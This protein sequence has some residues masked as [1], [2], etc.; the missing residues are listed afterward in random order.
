MTDAERRLLEA[1]AWMCEQYLTGRHDG[2]LDHQCMTAGENAVELLIE[3]GLVRPAGRGGTW[4]KAGLALLNSN[5]DTPN[6]R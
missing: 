3:Y 6:T 1:L 4:T 2:V 5:L